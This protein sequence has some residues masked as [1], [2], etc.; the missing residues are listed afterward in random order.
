ML[1]QFIY[2]CKHIKNDKYLNEKSFHKFYR[3]GKT[4]KINVNNYI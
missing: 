3:N 4:Y 1:K 2:T